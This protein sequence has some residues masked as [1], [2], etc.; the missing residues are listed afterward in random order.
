M[1]VAII[2]PCSRSS[3]GDFPACAAFAAFAASEATVVMEISRPYSACP[4]SLNNAY[5]H[6]HIN[7][8]VMAYAHAHILR[9]PNDDSL[10]PHPPHAV[11]YPLHLPS[12]T[13]APT[14]HPAPFHKYL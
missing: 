9:Q 8:Q 7:A 6:A 13:I 1:L 11:G 2:Q 3:L 12:R 14:K 10:S 4:C 5:A